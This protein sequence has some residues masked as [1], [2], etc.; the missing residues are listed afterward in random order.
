MLNQ[1]SSIAVFHFEADL[2]VADALSQLIF[3]LNSLNF[4]G[5][6]SSVLAQRSH[7][8]I[9]YYDFPVFEDETKLSLM[10]HLEDLSV[11]I[12]NRSLHHYLSVSPLIPQ[13]Q[14]RKVMD[15]VLLEA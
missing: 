14:V 2:R 15:L 13:V 4:V 7:S 5:R 10:Q 12:I 1:Q 9:L 11:A 8:H 6:D 3:I